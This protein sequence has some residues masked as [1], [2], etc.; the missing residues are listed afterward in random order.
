MSYYDRQKAKNWLRE[1][2]PAVIRITTV[3]RQLR[4]HRSH[5]L[6][7]IHEMAAAGEICVRKSREGKYTYWHITGGRD[8]GQTSPLT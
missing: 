2:T 4:I 1:N 6:E 3:V 5:F 7:A 8:D